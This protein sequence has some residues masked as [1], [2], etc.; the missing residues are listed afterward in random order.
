[1]DNK[2]DKLK[3]NFKKW[4]L[5]HSTSDISRE[6]TKAGGHKKI[7]EEATMQTGCNRTAQEFT[8][9]HFGPPFPARWGIAPCNPVKQT[10]L[11]RML[12]NLHRGRSG[13]NHGFV[14]V[15]IKK[16]G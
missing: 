8:R 15:G 7:S 4:M 11:F 10:P 9:P 1:M 3:S 6:Y 2:Y 14:D 12:H 5:N 16:E 13:Q